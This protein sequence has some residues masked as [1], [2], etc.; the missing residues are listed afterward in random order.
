M[1]RKVSP[2]KGYLYALGGEIRARR[3]ARNLSQFALAEHAGIHPNSLGRLERGQY[4]PSV[5]LLLD[6]THKLDTTLSE[7]F[8]AA[9]KKI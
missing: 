9:E 1:P 8:A 2:R 5:F 7:L 6:L 4:N 3:L